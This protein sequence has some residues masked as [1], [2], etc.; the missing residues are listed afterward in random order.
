MVRYESKRRYAEHWNK[1]LEKLIVSIPGVEMSSV[2]RMVEAWGSGKFYAGICQ[3][4]PA[5]AEGRI[6][7]IR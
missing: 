3:A 1:L 2:P 7:R 4:E 6:D 5:R